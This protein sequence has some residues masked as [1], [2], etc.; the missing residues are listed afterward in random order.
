MW[1]YAVQDEYLA[2]IDK[3]VSQK[4]YD[5]FVSAEEAYLAFLK[6]A[7]VSYG[8]DFP[9]DDFADHIVMPTKRLKV[10]ETGIQAQIDNI[11]MHELFLT[12]EL[13]NHG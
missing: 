6:E 7:C 1:M 2:I 11:V 9:V 10:A 12:Y 4:P 3:F 5:N 13:L 8:L